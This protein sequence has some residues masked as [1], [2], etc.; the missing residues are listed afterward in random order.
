KELGARNSATRTAEQTEIA[1]FWANDADGTMKPPGHLNLI[2][3]T[4]ADDQ[5]LSLQ[6]KARLFAMGSVAMGDAAI[7]AWD[8]KYNTDVDLWRPIDG[9]RRADEDGND[10]TISDPAW[11]PLAETTPPFPAYI[12]GHAT[13]AGA[14]AGAMAAFFGTDDIAFTVGTDDPD[15]IGVIR[16]FD[17]CSEA[18]MENAISR[19]YLGVHWWFDGEFGMASGFDLADWIA[20]NYFLEVPS[21]GVLVG[22]GGLLGLS[23]LRR[24]R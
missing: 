14:H 1:Y 6:D 13:F 5:H 20:A 21:P 10:A 9:I 22:L 18:A 15:A 12:S 4:V 23:A 17:S 19:V 11:E 3:Q 24:R 2:T 16:S 8:A 7:G